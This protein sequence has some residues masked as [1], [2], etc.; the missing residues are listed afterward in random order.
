MFVHVSEDT[1]DNELR[2]GQTFCKECENLT[3]LRLVERVRTVTAYWVL[4]STERNHFLICDGCDSQFRVKRSRDD[5]FTYADIDSL[6]RAA[7]GRF[8]PLL[9]RLIVFLALVSAVIPFFGLLL[10]WLAYRDRAWLTPK[11]LKA[12]KFALW[13]N[14]ALTTAFVIGMYLTRDV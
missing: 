3:T 13:M 10:I 7:G 4:K 8:V 1:V 9:T 14:L 11:M 12:M 6:M 2:R 5:D